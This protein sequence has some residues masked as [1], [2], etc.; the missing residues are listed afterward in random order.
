MTMSSKTA[1]RGIAVAFAACALGGV[2]A[3]HHR[4][5]DGGRPADVHAGGFATTAGDV[6]SGAGGYLSTTRAPTMS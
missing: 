1:R 3:G 5:A 2:A 6:L 4:A